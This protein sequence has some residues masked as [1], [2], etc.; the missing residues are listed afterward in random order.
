MKLSISN[1][2]FTFAGHGHYKVRYTT[3]NRRTKYDCLTSNMP[4]IDA[5]KNADYPKQNDLQDL[6]RLCRKG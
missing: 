4:L 3:P 5:T 2:E 1:F 6:R